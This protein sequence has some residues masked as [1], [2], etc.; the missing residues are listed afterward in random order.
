MGLK[1]DPCIDTKTQYKCQFI[2]WPIN[3]AYRF[4]QYRIG[5][6]ECT[7]IEQLVVR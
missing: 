5:N 7:D 2:Y 3:Q 6:P 4:W 1:I